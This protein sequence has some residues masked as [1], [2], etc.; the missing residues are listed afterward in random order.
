[1]TRS[2]A[3]AASFWQPSRPQTC[4]L[5]AG[6]SL[7]VDDRHVGP[8]RRDREHLPVAVRRREL[9]DQRVG[10]RQVGLEVAPERK[11]R[12]VRRARRVPGDHPEMAVLLELRADAEL[13]DGGRLDPPADRVQAADAGIAEPR[14]DELAGD[15]GRDHLV[16]DH[17]GGHPGEREVAPAAGG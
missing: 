10:H 15:A 4:V 16:V 17:V 6:G 13:G 1:M 8:E 12:Q 3:N 9:A 7:G 5:P 2:A 11:E 14:E